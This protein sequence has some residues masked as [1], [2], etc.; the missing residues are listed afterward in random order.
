ML[1]TVS[2]ARTNTSSQ[3]KHFIIDCDL[4]HD[5]IVVVNQERDCADAECLYPEM[6]VYTP[7]ELGKIGELPEDTLLS[8]HAFKKHLHCRIAHVIEAPEPAEEL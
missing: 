4:F 8:I 3:R 6:A 5:R 7:S 1:Q 2:A